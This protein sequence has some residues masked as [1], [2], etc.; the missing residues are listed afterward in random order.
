MPLRLGA[1]GIG[2]GQQQAPV[3]MHTAAGPQL[4]AVDDVGVAV[5][6][7]RGAQAGQVGAGLG[8]G[9]ALDPDL[10]VEDRG[11]VASALLVG[12][13]GQQGRRGVVDADEG[14]H[15]P[16]RVVRGQFLVEHDLLGDRHVR[17]PIRAA[18]AARRSPALC[19]SANQAFWKRTNSSSPTPVSR[20]ACSI[21]SAW[22]STPT[23][24]PWSPS[25]GGPGGP[26]GRLGDRDRGRRLRSRRASSWP[27]AGSTSSTPAP[28]KSIA[29]DLDTRCARAR[30]PPG[31][32]VGP[33]PGCEPKPLK[34][35]PP[36]SGPQGPFAGI[37][38]GPDGTLYVS[39]DGDGSVLALRRDRDMT[40]TVDAGRPPLPAGG[41]HPAQGDRRRGVSGGFAA[42]H[43]TRTV[44][45]VRG[46]P[47]HRPRGAAPAARRQPGR[48]A[49]AR[50]HPGRARGRRRIPM[51]R[52]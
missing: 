17:R 32:P 26:A 45:A 15:Q 6:S 51:R 50:G 35:M 10:A 13:R 2:A 25:R 47:L 34:G 5:A 30:S 48:V 23:A 19:S 33:P 7:G 49:A 14:Q 43:R 36:F 18:S 8:F 41:A 1:S 24:G 16:R 4:L 42:A 12:A 39:A 21:R 40:L 38:A 29:F 3:G 31:L 28:R 27:T 52:T 22:R 11:Q 46:Q 20:P 9:E 44:R 37:A